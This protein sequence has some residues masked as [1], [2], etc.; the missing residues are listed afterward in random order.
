MC[1]ISLL[2]TRNHTEISLVLVASYYFLYLYVECFDKNAKVC[3]ASLLLP[4]LLNQHHC[5]DQHH[6]VVT[7]YYVKVLQSIGFI[8][9]LSLHTCPIT[10][11]IVV[12]VGGGCA[13]QDL[14]Q[15]HQV[16]TPANQ[17]PFV[18]LAFVLLLDARH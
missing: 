10:T 17:M 2:T 15:T 1:C 14:Q 13:H 5:H 3:I 16:S 11:A 4:P 18:F 12:N 7:I 6:P 8:L 9:T